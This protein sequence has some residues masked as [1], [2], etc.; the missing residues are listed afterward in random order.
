[1]IRFVWFSCMS[2]LCVGVQGIVGRFRG[3]LVSMA[4]SWLVGFTVLHKRIQTLKDKQVILYRTI[5]VKLLEINSEPHNCHTVLTGKHKVAE[6]YIYSVNMGSIV[7]TAHTAH[8]DTCK[9]TSLNH[10][11]TFVCN[12]IY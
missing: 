12:I 7:D 4:C 10:V 3:E 6:L 9:S 1:M 8:R 11:H 5:D 2:L